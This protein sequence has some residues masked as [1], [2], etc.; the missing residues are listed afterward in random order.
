MDAPHS[1]NDAAPVHAHRT[2]GFDSPWRIESNKIV[3]RL[4]I[5]SSGTSKYKRNTMWSQFNTVTRQ[6]CAGQRQTSITTKQ[7][8][9]KTKQYLRHIGKLSIGGFPAQA[10]AAQRWSKR[11]APKSHQRT[12]SGEPTIVDAPRPQGRRSSA[13]ATILLVRSGSAEQKTIKSYWN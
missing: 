6:R 7:K 13:S 11:K 8:S 10:G 2:I 12:T 4:V 3:L 1:R 9:K 5:G